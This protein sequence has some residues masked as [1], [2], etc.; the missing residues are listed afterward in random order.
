MSTIDFFVIE[1]N[2]AKG[3]KEVTT[4]IEVEPHPHRPVR[5]SISTKD[6]DYSYWAFE[7]PHTL[8]NVRMVGPIPKPPE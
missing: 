2:L 8:P 4:V 3:V 6:A 1:G 7:A 5:M